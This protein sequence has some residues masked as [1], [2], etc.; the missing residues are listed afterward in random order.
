M[1]RGWQSAAKF[2]VTCWPNPVHTTADI[3]IAYADESEVA[4]VT[5]ELLD[6]AGRRMWTRQQERAGTVSWQV[7]DGATPPGI[8]V[9]RVSVRMQQGDVQTKTDK[10]IVAGQ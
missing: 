10:I 9:L 3:R 4:Q 7:T 8:Y 1:V 2:D 6:L 5:L